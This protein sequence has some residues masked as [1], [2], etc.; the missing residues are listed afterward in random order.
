MNKKITSNKTKYLEVKK[1]L[2][3]PVT[4]GYDFLFVY[5]PRLVML[6]LKKD[7]GT[8]HVLSSKSNKVYNLNLSHYVVLSYIALH[9]LDIKWEQ[10]LVKIFNCRTKQLLDENC[11]YLLYLWFSC[12]T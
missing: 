6:E 7:K 11:K 10:N 3:S 4:N 1:K 12:L 5:Q 9:F 2:K 8:D